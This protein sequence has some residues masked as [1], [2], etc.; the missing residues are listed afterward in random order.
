LLLTG[1]NIVFFF[2]CRS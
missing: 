1:L 2:V